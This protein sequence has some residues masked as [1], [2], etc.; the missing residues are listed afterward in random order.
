MPKANKPAQS[1]AATR[2]VRPP[3][4]KAAPKPASKQPVQAVRTSASRRKL[5][6][7]TVATAGVSKKALI[8]TLLRRQGG[9]SLS[10]LQA[11]TGWQGHSI[12]AAM[13]GLRKA[14]GDITRSKDDAGTSLFRLI[15]GS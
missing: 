4:P 13:T 15:G 3:A 6:A 12:R 14:G 8:A 7:E 1:A 9:A 2:R 11:A 5:Q 10:D